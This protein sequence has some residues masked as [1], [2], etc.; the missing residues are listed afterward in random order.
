MRKW[1]KHIHNSLFLLFLIRRPLHVRPY[2][3]M[4]V[5][6]VQLHLGTDFQCALKATKTKTKK[7]VFPYGQMKI[8][9]GLLFVWVGKRLALLVPDGNLTIG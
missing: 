5:V 9:T 2:G 6:R 3:N 4:C 8:G 1:N 7:D